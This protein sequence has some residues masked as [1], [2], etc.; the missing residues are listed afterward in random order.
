MK[1]KR[2]DRADWAR[3][4][5]RR[6]VMKYID[7]PDFR[8]YV[9]LLCIDAVRDPLIVNF[10]G[11]MVRIADKGY[12]WVQHFPQEANYTLTSNFDQAGTF[13]RGY[14]DIC[15]PAMLDTTGVLWYD[16]L[17]LDLDIAPSGK[18]DILDADE[19]DEA[20]RD[21]NIGPIDYDIA[22]REVSTLITAIEEDLFPVLWLSEAHRE[23]LLKLV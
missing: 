8:G 9:S 10:M 4:T 1:K 23:M 2:A 14:V 18:I 5:K 16:D 19:L 20:L 12:T 13:V 15:K 21:G 6:F 3:I 17:Y 22:W 11:E 7:V